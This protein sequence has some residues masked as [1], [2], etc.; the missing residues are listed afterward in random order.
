MCRTTSRSGRSGR[1]RSGQHAFGCTPGFHSDG[2]TWFPVASGPGCVGDRYT[3]TTVRITGTGG[4][5]S[6]AK[7]RLFSVR[8]RQ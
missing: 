5:T 4:G 3:E 7:N 8:N 1:T 2:W 6:R